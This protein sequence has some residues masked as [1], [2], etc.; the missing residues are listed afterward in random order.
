MKFMLAPDSFKGSLSAE[1]AVQAM[2][3]GIQ[4]VI[5]EAQL[6]SMP[7]A[8]GG[9]GTIEVLQ[10][11]LGGEKRYM[12]VP[13]PY[14]REVEA[15]YLYTRQMAV[16]EL[17]QASGLTLTSK[18]ERNPMQAST[19]GTGL[20]IRDALERGVKQICLTLGGS[21]TNDGGAGIAKA[22]GISLIDEAGRTVEPNC[23]GLAC[24]KRVNKDK[25]HPLVEQ[26]NFVIA[27]DVKN[28]LCG[29]NGASAIYGPQKGANTV[30]VQQMDEILKQYGEILEKTSGRSV[31]SLEGSGAAGGAALPLLA[32]ANARLCSGIDLV[33]DALSFDRQL[34]D[35]DWVFSGE[36]KID[37]Q[38]SF[39]KAIDGIAQR[40]RKQ[41]VPVA[42]FAGS[43]GMEPESCPEGMYLRSIN[44][45][46]GTLEEHM[47]HAYENLRK[48]VS[49]F[50]LEEE[51][52]CRQY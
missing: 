51:K 25:I 8:D 12:H 17:A 6:V 48:A 23:A 29:S 50:L 13:G 44:P 39:G 21:A 3:E 14:G 5:P 24:L 34:E 47:K 52:Q 18:E 26:C 33:L 9:E 49:D 4:T 37:A 46:E 41:G 40:A 19:Y 32:F 28:P 15:C 31:V 27:C 1:Q 43:L 2:T 35:V 10:R 45:A 36:G 38:T 16:I 22:L 7:I 42:V 20:L 11:A 30:M